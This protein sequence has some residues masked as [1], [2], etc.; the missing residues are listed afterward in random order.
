MN[1]KIFIDSNIL[2]YAHDLDADDRHRKAVEIVRDLWT[3]QN[4]VI[5][6]QVLQEFYVNVTRKIPQPLDKSKARE[7]VRNY[8]LW[9][10]ETI[11][12]SDVFRASEIE[13]ANRISFWDALI[14]VAAAKSGASVLLS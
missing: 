1:G 14:V 11:D 8:S 5:S 6:T 4:G 2:I 13:E 12:S 10:T 7:V 3:N 9:Q